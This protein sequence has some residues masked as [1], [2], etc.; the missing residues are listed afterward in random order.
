MHQPSP[1]TAAEVSGTLTSNFILPPRF[2]NFP[3]LGRSLL[4]LISYQS[5]S[6]FLLSYLW[7]S[8]TSRACAG[9]QVTL[10]TQ[11][12]ATARSHALQTAFGKS[13]Q[14]PDRHFHIAGTGW[15][16]TSTKATANS[17][18]TGGLSTQTQSFHVSSGSNGFLMHMSQSSAHARIWGAFPAP[19]AGR[20]IGSFES[21]PDRAEM[22]SLTVGSGCDCL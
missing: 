7:F 1:A 4:I 11:D 15:T 16:N 17:D 9:L 21:F 2:S 12:P 10:A 22:L 13:P 19:M 20:R 14:D 8:L 6:V 3:F 5:F 18:T